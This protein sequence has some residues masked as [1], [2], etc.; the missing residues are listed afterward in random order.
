MPVMLWLIS[1]RIVAAVNSAIGTDAIRTIRVLAVGSAPALHTMRLALATAAAPEAPVKTRETTSPGYKESLAVHQ[2]VVP[3][4]RVDPG[5]AQ[6][7]ERQ[8][9]AMRE[10]SVRAFPEQQGE[11]DGTSVSIEKARGQHLREAE[12][13]RAKAVRRARAERPGRE[14]ETAAKVTVPDPGALRST[15]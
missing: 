4:R 6:A 8:T 5:I 3:E 2:A 11:P 15:A 7:V 12:A 9:R 10:L 13:V 1:A 14:T